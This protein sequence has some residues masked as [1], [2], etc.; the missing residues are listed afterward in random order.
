[1]TDNELTG[2]YAGLLKGNESTLKTIFKNLI[3]N[4]RLDYKE[5]I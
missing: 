2:S 5:S 3:P 4:W 1:M